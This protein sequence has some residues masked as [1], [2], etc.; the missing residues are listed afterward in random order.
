VEL[1][2]VASGG[3]RSLGRG[4]F[5]V[6]TGKRGTVSVR[7]NLPKGRTKVLLTARLASGV[8]YRQNITARI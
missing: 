8:V 3:L 5:S 4:R 6:P 7:V 2:L 1:Q